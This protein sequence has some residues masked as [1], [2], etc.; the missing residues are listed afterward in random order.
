MPIAA[1]ERIESLVTD[2]GSRAE[3]ARA[4]HVDR[5]QVTRWLDRDQDP[6][7][8]N[9]RKVEGVELALARL[10]RQYDR[11][12]ALRWLEGFNAQLG[13]RRPIDLL[14]RGRLSE[15]LDAIDAD[16]IGSFA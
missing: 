4:L 6:G 3:V 7:P 1:K 16:E 10:L 9:L 15:V 14:A 2:L 5:S 12:S 8:D 13:D 11:D